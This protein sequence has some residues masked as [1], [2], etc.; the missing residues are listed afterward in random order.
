[1]GST[2]APSAA[3]AA[4]DS[5]FS[6]ARLEVAPFPVVALFVSVV[7]ASCGVGA[8]SAEALRPDTSGPLGRA[9]VPVPTWLISARAGAG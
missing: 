4:F 1:V 8:A 3:K 7:V 9:G 2:V 5:G 6:T